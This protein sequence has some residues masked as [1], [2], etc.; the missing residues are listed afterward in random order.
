MA[1]D[2]RTGTVSR[3]D[4]TGNASL[5]IVSNALL[6]VDDPDA[7]DWNIRRMVEQLQPR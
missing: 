1:W 7:L 4:A 6:Q 5:L 3:T 2:A